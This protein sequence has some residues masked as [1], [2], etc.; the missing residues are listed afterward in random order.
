MEYIAFDYT[1]CKRIVNALPGAMVQYLNGDLAPA[2]VR[3]DGIGGIDYR[4]STKGHTGTLVPVYLYGAGAD[5]IRGV[6]DN[7]ELARR[8]MELLG[9]E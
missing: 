3:Q 6:M 5:A 8:I 9:L 2:A 1:T 7:T 4:F